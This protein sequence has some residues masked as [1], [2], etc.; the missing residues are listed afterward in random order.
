MNVSKKQVLAILK[1]VLQEACWHVSVGGCT[2]PSFSLALGSKVKR[3]RA[4]RNPAQ[5]AAFQKYEPQ[6][7]FFVWC[8]WRLERGDLMVT[9]DDG[10]EGEITRGLERII[11]RSVTRIG[12]TAPM[13]DLVIQFNDGLRLTVFC[14]QMGNNERL[15]S[16]WHATVRHI[17]VYAGPGSKFRIVEWGGE[18]GL[19]NWYLSLDLMATEGIQ[20][21]LGTMLLST[22]D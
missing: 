18:K 3:K 12:I 7:A 22:Q 8:A 1:P 16:N 13:W 15:S 11:G 17:K 9:S 20:P 5:P 2:L 6:I 19:G 10:D 4:L 21:L 14:N